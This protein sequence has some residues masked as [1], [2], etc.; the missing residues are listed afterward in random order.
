VTTIGSARAGSSGGVRVGSGAGQYTRARAIEMVKK[1]NTRSRQYAVA[2][3]HPDI[4]RHQQNHMLPSRELDVEDE[5]LDFIGQL[6]AGVEDFKVLRGSVAVLS[7]STST[8]FAHL[9]TDA[10]MIS[11]GN[12]L[13]VDIYQV[14]R[15]YIFGDDEDEDDDDVDTG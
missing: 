12:V 1:R 14:K 10:S 15:G 11:R 9:L 13:V 6:L 3:R 7:L 4:P 8:E 2:D 5:E